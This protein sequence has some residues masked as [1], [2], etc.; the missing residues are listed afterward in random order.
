MRILSF[1]ENIESLLHKYVLCVYIKHTKKLRAKL[2]KNLPNP[3]VQYIKII[4]KNL[5]LVTK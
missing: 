3:I 4:K 5:L 2:K 1:K